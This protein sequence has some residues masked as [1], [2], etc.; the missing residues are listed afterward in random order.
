MIVAP[1]G[2]IK[3]GKKIISRDTKGY[4][5]LLNRVQKEFDKIQHLKSKELDI[6]VIIQTSKESGKN[7]RG[8]NYAKCGH[9]DS[10]KREIIMIK[11]NA[12]TP[13]KHLAFLA[14]EFGHLHHFINNYSDWRIHSAL[15]RERYADKFAK[16]ITGIDPK[17][18]TGKVRS[19]EAMNRSR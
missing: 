16:K 5:V 10:L 9:F 13:E 19:I 4:K 7:N 17:S 18:I 11:H 1:Y 2:R 15:H 3:D 6:T 12:S 14:H 8:K